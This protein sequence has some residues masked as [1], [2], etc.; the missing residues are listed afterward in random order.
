[1][2]VYNHHLDLNTCICLRCFFVFST[3]MKPSFGRLS[4]TL[5][6]AS[7]SANPRISSYLTKLS[8]RHG[9][10]PPRC[11]ERVV[12]LPRTAA[13]GNTSAVS[14]PA[15]RQPTKTPRSL[16]EFF[17]EENPSFEADTV[18]LSLRQLRL[19][20]VFAFNNNYIYL[21]LPGS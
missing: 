9:T 10:S 1:M 7:N 16:V 6:Q 14:A 11:N 17:G 3:M 12:S 19:V 13:S 2:P 4:L 8:Q 21:D 18:E 15:V 20:S 5:F